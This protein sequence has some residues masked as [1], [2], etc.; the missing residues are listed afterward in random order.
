[1]PGTGDDDR[2]EVVEVLACLGERTTFAILISTR[3]DP[4][5]SAVYLQKIGTV[6]EDDSRRE[7][8]ANDKRAVPMN[9]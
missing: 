4:I 5:A 2:V 9:E 8:G 7:R 1:M 6:D 3:Q